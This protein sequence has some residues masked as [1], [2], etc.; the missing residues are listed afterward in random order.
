M[1]EGL[2]IGYDIVDKESYETAFN[3]FAEDGLTHA[4]DI[5]GMV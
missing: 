5:V 1:K 3:S 4:W 2:Q